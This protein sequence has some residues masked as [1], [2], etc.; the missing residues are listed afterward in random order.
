MATDQP[1]PDP[2]AF[3][4][5]AM[6]LDH[7]DT[8]WAAYRDAI[9]T[10]CDAEHLWS[11]VP[12]WTVRQVDGQWLIDDI[13]DRSADPAPFTS[14]A[15]RMWHI[16]VDCLDSYSR[17]AFGSQS[18]PDDMAWYGTAAEALARTDAAWGHFRGG[19]AA[20]DPAG[21]ANPLGDQFGP[22]GTRPYA[23][24]AL[25]AHAEVTHH[26]AEVRLLRDLYREHHG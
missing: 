26:A 22:F 14:V 23:A 19:F 24:L 2:A 21:W 7:L 8:W 9:D 15:W 4:V 12:G 17:R 10:L 20:L 1:Q 25:H 5:G 6:V 13:P 3:D 18:G 11:P 16:A